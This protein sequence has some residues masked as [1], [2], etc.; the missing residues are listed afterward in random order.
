MKRELEN[1]TLKEIA[2]LMFEY[3]DAGGEID[4]VKETRPEWS[5]YEFHYDLRFPIQGKPVYIESR[6][7]Y[8]LPFK[9]DFSTILVVNIHDP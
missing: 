9:P 3:V 2:R 1:I 4:E 6:L 5:D 8:K 7:H